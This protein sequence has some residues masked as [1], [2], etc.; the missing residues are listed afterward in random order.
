MSKAIVSLSGGMDS[1]TVLAKMIDEG[2]D[3]ECI[4]FSYGSKHNVY[5]NSAALEISK[6]YKVPFK[7]Y[8]LEGFMADLNSNLLKSGD[9]IPEG[10]YEQENMS[11]TVVPGRNLI[12]ASIVA[13][14]AESRGASCIALG[15]HSGDH[16]IY[17]DCRPE[18]VE[19][20]KTVIGASTENK[21]EVLA[22]FLTGDK[23]SIIEWGLKNNVPYELT[24]TCYKDQEASCGKC[25]SCTERLEAFE[26]N[27][28][29]D[30][31]EYDQN[32]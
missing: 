19:A 1:A 8:G 22:P 23:I 3:V 30:P 15:V 14:I 21:V 20:L 32:S 26:L 10:H 31:I 28:V 25:G 18:F 9:E 27:G 6:H 7:V 17:P 5:E 11:L 24:R 2:Y 29:K 13:S 12:F 16:A 4:G